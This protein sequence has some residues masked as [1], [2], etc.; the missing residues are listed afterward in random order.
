MAQKDENNQTL[1]PITL[2]PVLGPDDFI[3]AAG[4]SCS[5]NNGQGAGSCQCGSVN[6]GG[7]GGS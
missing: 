5:S 1:H 3:N 6:G 2:F 7:S 4:C